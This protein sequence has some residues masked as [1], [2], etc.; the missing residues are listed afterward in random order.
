MDEL[1]AY[2]ALSRLPGLN[3][4]QKR[5]LVD[6]LPAIGPLFEGHLSL[7]DHGLMGIFRSFQGFPAILKEREALDAMGARLISLKDETYPPLLRAIPDAPI[8]LYARGRLNKPGERILAVVG[9]RRASFEGMSLAEKI[10]ETL[11]SLAI[12]V[13]SGLA[14]GIDASSHLGALKGEGKTIAV[15]GCGLDICYPYENRLLFERIGEEGLLLTEY[16]LGERPLRHHFPE[17]NRIIAGLSRGV[18]VVEAAAKSGSLITARLGLEYGRE[19][20]AVP[21]S[22]F[23]QGHKGA[24]N[25]IKQGARLVDGIEEIVT[26][27]FR[28]TVVP[29]KPVVELEEKEEYIYSLIGSDLLHVD[30]VIEKSG[31]ETKDVMAVLTRIE[32]KGLVQAVPGGFYL[33][34]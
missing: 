34:T 33:R 24:N 6:R 8:V 26:A 12:C 23:H 21:G 13:A 9:S 10:G 2:L 32:M 30:Q 3:R 20:M 7:P 29:S 25:L 16:G 27:C 15:L 4:I 31:M 18:L 28:D 17:R 14:S 1:T 19:V 22:I 11:S 5:E